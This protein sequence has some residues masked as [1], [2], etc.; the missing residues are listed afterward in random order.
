MKILGTDDNFSFPEPG[1]TM[2]VITCVDH[3]DAYYLSKHPAQRGLH[4]IGWNRRD[5]NKFSCPEFGSSECPCP[6]SSLRVVP[7][8]SA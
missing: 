6:Y 8:A 3:P 7:E 2:F 4:F 5:G 1:P